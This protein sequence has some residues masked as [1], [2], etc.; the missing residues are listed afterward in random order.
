VLGE[1]AS[2]S[3]APGS[4]GATAPQGRQP[5]AMEHTRAP[6]C[7]PAD[8]DQE[9]VPLAIPCTNDAH[10]Q[11]PALCIVD[12]HEI[13]DAAALQQT[14]QNVVSAAPELRRSKRLRGMALA[15]STEDATLSEA[16]RL[17]TQPPTSRQLG[18]KLSR[19]SLKRRI[20]EPLHRELHRPTT[21]QQTA[22]TPKS[23]RPAVVNQDDAPAVGPYTDDTYLHASTMP[24]LDTYDEHD[25]LQGSSFDI[26]GEPHAAPS[27]R[28]SK[29]IRTIASS[30]H[31]GAA[32]PTITTTRAQT[33]QSL[34][35]S[36]RI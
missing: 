1:D 25:A 8:T 24:L 22:Q 6:G 33:Q 16:A 20:P 29:R 23:P 21:R 5:A 10:P 3:Q 17:P 11:A 9:A 32:P 34:R 18:H 15:Q 31:D 19:Q 2:Q 26:D 35:R 7:E 13:D 36:K 27:L 28:R 4:A 30:G 14:T 12:A